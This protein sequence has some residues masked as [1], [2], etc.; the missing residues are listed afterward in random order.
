MNSQATLISKSQ[1]RDCFVPSNASDGEQCAC[2]AIGVVATGV[3]ATPCV[4][5]IDPAETRRRRSKK[6]AE[7]QDE[8]QTPASRNSLSFLRLHQQFPAFC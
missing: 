1:T 8:D 4:A 7:Y 6:G 5:F 2:V 3:V